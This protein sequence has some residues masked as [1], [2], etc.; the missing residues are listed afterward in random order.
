M[1]SAQAR[2]RQPPHR[3]PFPGD[4]KRRH[5]ESAYPHAGKQRLICFCQGR[6]H[7]HRIRKLVGVEGLEPTLLAEHD[8]ESRASTNSATPPYVRS[9]A[10]R[11]I[12]IMTFAAAAKRNLHPRAT[13]GSRQAFQHIFRWRSGLLLQSRGFFPTVRAQNT[14]PLCPIPDQD[15]PGPCCL[16]FLRPVALFSCWSP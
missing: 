4:V 14:V 5:T 2:P 11:A 8:F 13:S 15:S 7:Q 1:G 6:W 10:G 12:V 16:P 9:G 3:S